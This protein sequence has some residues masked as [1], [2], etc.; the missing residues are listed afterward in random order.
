[1][2]T[3]AVEIYSD[4]ANAAVLRHPSR[5][6]PGVLI[7]GDT[8]FNLYWQVELAI[9]AGEG[10]LPDRGQEELEDLRDQLRS[11]LEHYKTVLLAHGIALPFTAPG[12][13]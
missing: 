11:L 9:A 7:Q 13:A 3:E 1:M 4:S 12:E 6:Y 2:R 10:A 5:K 8:L